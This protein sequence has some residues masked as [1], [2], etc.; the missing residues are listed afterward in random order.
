MDRTKAIE[1]YE[2]LVAT[3]PGVERKGDAMPY[4]SV[5]GHMFSIVT[6]D[7][8]L[9]IRLPPAALATFL[10]KYKTVLCE[11]YGHVMREYAVVPDALLEK[12]S[13]LKRH[14]AASY[15]FVAAMKPKPTTKPKASRTAKST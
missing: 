8:R 11:Q 6:K 4:T 13:A 5:N 15:R 3:Q 9:A 1:L 7:S 2:K 12:T 10:K 14:F